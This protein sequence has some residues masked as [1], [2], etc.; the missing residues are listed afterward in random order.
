MY[1]VAELEIKDNTES[2]QTEMI[3]T[4]QTELKRSSHLIADLQQK[5]SESDHERAK[6]RRKTCQCKTDC[7]TRMCGCKKH[8]KTCHDG[9]ACY[10]S[11]CINQLTAV[12]VIS[13]IE[14]SQKNM[15]PTAI[16][17]G[18]SF[19]IPPGYIPTNKCH[20]KGICS[21][22]KCG[23]RKHHKTC[24]DACAC[25]SKK[26]SNQLFAEMA[27]TDMESAKIL[28]PT[29]ITA[30]KSLVIPSDFKPSWK[31]LCKNICSNM[32]CGC[33]RNGKKCHERCQRS[34][35]MP[36]PKQMYNQLNIY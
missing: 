13:S 1:V 10:S 12:R 28:H 3:E 19:G 20:C 36:P 16:T 33:H 17:G 11:K 35:S 27:K 21:N 29:I 26:C 32:M 5:L 8:G 31:C 2:L 9:C 24:H 22:N 23:C 14:E 15:H 7:S 4:L 18:A 34:P 6:Q 30:G 25:D